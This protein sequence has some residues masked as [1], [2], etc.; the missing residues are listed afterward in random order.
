[1]SPRVLVV[2]YV[3]GHTP[4]VPCLHPFELS[5]VL[6]PRPSASRFCPPGRAFS[7]GPEM[8][9]SCDDNIKVITFTELQGWNTEKEKIEG[10]GRKDWCKPGEGQWRGGA[11]RSPLPPPPPQ[12]PGRW[13]LSKAAACHT[14]D[15]HWKEDVNTQTVKFRIEWEARTF[16][17]ILRTFLILRSCRRKINLKENLKKKKKKTH[18]PT[19]QNKT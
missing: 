12:L 18:T 2:L 17:R 6:P 3:I 7:Q 15:A 14:Q 19:P 13:L 10:E 16:M 1:M 5:F 4:A 11:P 9:G 8:G